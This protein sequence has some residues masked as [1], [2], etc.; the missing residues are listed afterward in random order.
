MAKK[1][2]ILLLAG[3]HGDERSGPYILTEFLKKKSLYFQETAVIEALPILN[4]T[5]F[6]LKRR[7]N[8]EG[9]DLNRC[10][11]DIPCKN[12]PDECKKLRRIFKKTREPYDL[13][14]SLHEDLEQKDFYLYAAGLKKSSPLVQTIFRAATTLGISLYSGPDDRTF[15]KRRVIAGYINSHKDL[16]SPALEDY[17]FRKGVAKAVLTLEIPGKLNLARKLKLGRAILND[18]FHL[19]K[20]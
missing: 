15:G 11:T 7:E 5:G 1:Q 16:N 9:R 20:K 8:F 14:I 10:F 13:A 2:R 6:L 17:L 3:I 19:L 12:E 18:V 4:P